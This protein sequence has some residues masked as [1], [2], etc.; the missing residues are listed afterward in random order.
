M[1]SRAE[2]LAALRK[3]AASIDIEDTEAAAARLLERISTR[4]D[5]LELR[6]AL[7]ELGA[8]VLVNPLA[9]IGDG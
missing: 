9:G 5:A 4:A 3:I 1:G 6:A 8:R 2:V 7:A